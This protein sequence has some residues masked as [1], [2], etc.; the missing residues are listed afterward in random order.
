MDSGL[1]EHPF[2]NLEG[3]RD[4]RRTEEDGCERLRSLQVMVQHVQ[5]NSSGR[6]PGGSGTKPLII[7]E[8]ENYNEGSKGTTSK[9]TKYQYVLGGNT[10]KS[11][12]HNQMC[13]RCDLMI[14]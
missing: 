4:A 11:C 7:I 14:V 2:F 13:Q 3:A 10:H 9:A 5:K 6:C 8:L 1:P 12:Q